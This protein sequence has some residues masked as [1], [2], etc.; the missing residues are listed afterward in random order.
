MLS[1]S[2]KLI[3]LPFS[4]YCHLSIYLSSLLQKRIAIKPHISIYLSSLLQKRIAIMPPTLFVFKPE[5][6]VLDI[7]E[8]LLELF[9]HGKDSRAG[10]L[11]VNAEG[12]IVLGQEF[13]P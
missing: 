7:L 6:A 8:L 5:A 3:E 10:V 12:R 2:A 9:Q 11:R 1:N 13:L 4:Q